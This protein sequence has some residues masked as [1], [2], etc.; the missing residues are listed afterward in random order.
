VWG[1]G[2]TK[3]DY[4]T[5]ICYAVD[6]LAQFSGFVGSSIADPSFKLEG[7]HERG[8]IVMGV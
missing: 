1:Y 8:L 3:N 7:I 4:F 5:P 2:T 6:D